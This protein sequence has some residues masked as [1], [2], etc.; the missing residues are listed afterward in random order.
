MPRTRSQTIN[1]HIREDR[2]QKLIVGKNNSAPNQAVVQVYYSDL[3]KKFDRDEPF[4]TRIVIESLDGGYSKEV[5]VI[6]RKAN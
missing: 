6:V 1:T 4:K 5:E 3:Y 2:T